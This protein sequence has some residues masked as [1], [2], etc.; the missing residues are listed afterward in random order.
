MKGSFPEVWTVE[1]AGGEPARSNRPAVGPTYR[2]LSVGKGD[3]PELGS[4]ATLYE[5][6]SNSAMKYADMPCLGQRKVVDGKA[7]PF[8]YLSYKEAFRQ[9]IVLA[10]S[11]EYIGV[12]PHSTCGIYGVNTPTWMLAMQACNALTVY[13]VPLYDTLG[14]QAIEFIINH[15]EISTIFIQESSLSKL[16]EALPKCNNHVKVVI[17]LG[18]FSAEAKSTLEARGLKAYAFDDL[19]VMGREKPFEPHAPNPDDIATIMYTSGTTGE[20]KGVVLKHSNLVSTIAGLTK[21]LQYAKFFL[22][23]RDLYLSY[24]PL[25]HIF[26]R[27]VEEAMLYHG[28]AIAYWQGDVKLLLDDVDAAK[29]TVFCGVPRVFDRVYNGATAKV[30]AGSFITKLLYK[31]GFSRKKAALDGGS[32]F[33]KATPFLDHLVFSKF[34]QR[35]GGRVRVI[36][37]GGAP[38]ARHVEDFLRVTMCCPVVQGYGLTES[39]AGSFV[40]IPNANQ[41][42]TVGVVFPNQECRLEAV[43]DM[44]YDPLGTP[45]RGEVCLRGPPIFTGYYKRPD[46]TK[47]ALDEEGWLHTGDVGEWQADGTMKIIDRKKNMFKLAQGEYV[48]AENLENVYGSTPGVEAIWVYGNSYEYALV[49][50]V[51][52]LQGPLQDW[53]E[54]QGISLEWEQLCRDPRTKKHILEQLKTTAQA[55]KLKGFE[56]IKNLVV[57]PTPL[58]M[59]RDLLTP[60]YKIKRPK[61][62]KYYQ[63]EIDSLYQ[64]IRNEG[65]KK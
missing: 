55:K 48:A 3:F 12:Q 2:H 57:E 15:A 4:A 14:P 31:F 34:K 47:D 1:V 19:L 64:E 18:S 54:S 52:P 5:L 42:G 37:S 62:L 25:A 38:L 24:L 16:L 63:K 61:M 35:L 33:E 30:Q 27:V 6:F 20:P 36:L 46:L 8:E 9:A 44:E 56:F 13:S 58:D 29:P 53:A 22:S 59:E 28:A 26:G 10:G 51:V 65:A 43:P 39:C 23:E 41:T 50:V 49:A 7:G 11:L 21:D 45:P 40:A 17:S 60:T 32:S